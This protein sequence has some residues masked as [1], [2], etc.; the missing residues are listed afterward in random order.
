VDVRIYLVIGCILAAVG[1]VFF[2]LGVSGTSGLIGFV[3]LKVAIGLV[4][5][6]L[7]TLLWL[8]AL[9]RLPLSKVYPFTILTFLMVY[10]ASFAMLGE[11]VS[12]SLLV[13]SAL[14]ISGLIVIAVS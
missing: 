13:G 10:V 4:S 2:K 11:K 5:Y 7:G 1:Q 12:L 8:M 6:G 3:N 9:A 14:I